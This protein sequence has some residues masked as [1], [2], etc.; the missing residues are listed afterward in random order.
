MKTNFKTLQIFLIERKISL[1][2]RQLNRTETAFN[3]P[4][5]LRYDLKSCNIQ[6]KE[7]NK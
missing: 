4:L 7:L 1:I 3:S 2:E 6:L 5:Q